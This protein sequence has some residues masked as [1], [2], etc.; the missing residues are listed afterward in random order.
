MVDLVMKWD[1]THLPLSDQLS[2]QVIH[3]WEGGGRADG[4]HG[5]DYPHRSSGGSGQS[6]SL[7][8]FSVSEST[9]SGNACAAHGE[10]FAQAVMYGGLPSCLQVCMKVGPERHFESQR[11]MED[12]L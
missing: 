5:P 2:L 4:A 12:P 8:C 7:L 11:E 3:L 1:C 10:R 9:T 6:F